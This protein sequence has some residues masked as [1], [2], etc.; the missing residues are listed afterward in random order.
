MANV[1]R[2]SAFDD[3]LHDLFRGLFAQPVGLEA[4]GA[5]ARFKVDVTEDENSYTLRA[6]MPGVKKDDITITIDGDEV[7]ISA[8]VKNETEVKDSDRILHAERYYGK[9]HR[10]FTLGQDVDEAGAQASYTDGVLQ[11]TLPKKAAAASR[12]ITIN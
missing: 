6:E 10:A 8:E 3:T 12:R 9:V 4:G 7:A 11:L 1:V 2:F 5:P